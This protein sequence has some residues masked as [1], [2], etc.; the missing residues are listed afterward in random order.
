LDAEHPGFC[1]IRFFVQ[2]VLAGVQY[3]LANGYR[4]CVMVGIS[5]GAWTTVLASALDPRIEVSYHIAGSLPFPMRA[6]GELADY[7]NHLPGLYSIANY[8]ELYVM[9]AD[10]PTRKQ[11][12]VFN[13]F[14]PVAWSGTR[15]KAYE[16]R[17]QDVL[18]RIGGGRFEVIIGRHSDHRISRPVLRRIVDDIA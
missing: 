5:G 17:V 18:E 11:V 10:Q 9:G 3:A 1:A 6:R 8:P 4:R 12:Q 15:G 16:A 13:Q 14:D 7:E 2:P